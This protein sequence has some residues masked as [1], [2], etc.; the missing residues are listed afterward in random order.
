MPPASLGLSQDLILSVPLLALMSARSRNKIH[1]PVNKNAVLRIW[2]QRVPRGREE[3]WRKYAEG[4]SEEWPGDDSDVAAIADFLRYA[5][6]GDRFYLQESLKMAVELRSGDLLCVTDHE[7][8]MTRLA[9]RLERLP[10]LCFDDM[11]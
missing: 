2:T 5:E 1:F 6:T 8:V 7:E 11:D 3:D 9:V 4:A 10:V